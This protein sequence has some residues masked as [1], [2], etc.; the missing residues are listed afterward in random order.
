[1]RAVAAGARVG[2]GDAGVR[3]TRSAAGGRPAGGRRDRRRAARH[4]RSH[5]GG[6]VSVRVGERRAVPAAL[7]RRNEMASPASAHARASAL[8]PRE[9]TQRRDALLTAALAIGDLLGVAVG[10]WLAR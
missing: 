10:Y 8:P 7:L 5:G 6:D 9:I 1:R 3:C 4:R 2:T